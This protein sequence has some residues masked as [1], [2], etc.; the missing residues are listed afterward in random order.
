[1]MDLGFKKE[2]LF[3]LNEG[4]TVW[5][6]KHEARVGEEIQTNNI[7]V[8]AYGVGDVGNVVLRD[9][10]ALSSEGMVVTVLVVDNNGNLTTRPRFFSRGF[11]FEKKEDQLFEEATKMIEKKLKPSKTKLLDMN[12]FKKELGRDLETFFFQE[13]GRRPL[14]LVDVIQI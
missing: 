2:K 7:Y 1:M 8:D 10:Q 12:N 3:L 14:I 4:E 11:V 13:R 6:T 9:R 5:F